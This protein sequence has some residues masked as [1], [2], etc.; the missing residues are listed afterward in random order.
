[1]SLEVVDSSLREQ[2]MS[3]TDNFG[4]VL[5]R[6]AVLC[7]AAV[8]GCAYAQTVAR[9]SPRPPPLDQEIV[10]LEARVRT[11]PQD[12]EARA[13][14]LRDYFASAPKPPLDDPQRRLARLDHI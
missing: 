5:R 13:Q 6:F 8:F 12:L 1:M 9:I 10:N 2:P 14:L 7:S 11:N 3:K 4:L